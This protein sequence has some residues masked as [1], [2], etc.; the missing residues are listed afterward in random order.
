MIEAVAPADKIRR[1]YD[2]AGAFYG[3]IFAPIERKARMRGVE[4]AN[5]Q[6]TDCILEVAFGTGATLVE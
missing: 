2:Y 3:T 5:I 4:L 6:A 1:A